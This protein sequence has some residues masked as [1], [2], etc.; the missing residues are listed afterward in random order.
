[1]TAHVKGALVLKI[2]EGKTTIAEPSWN[3][4]SALSEVV[5][6]PISFCTS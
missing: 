1:M 4:E 5:N 6:L 3:Y 2:I